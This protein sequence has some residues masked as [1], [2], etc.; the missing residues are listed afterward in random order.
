M[1][2]VV[3]VHHLIVRRHN[4]QHRLLE[5]AKNGVLAE[6]VS[7]LKLGAGM[8]FAAVSRTGYLQ[9]VAPINHLAYRVFYRLVRL[10]PHSN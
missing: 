8:P 3:V 4:Q 6:V 1:I 5:D 10:Q 2:P 9:I 7:G